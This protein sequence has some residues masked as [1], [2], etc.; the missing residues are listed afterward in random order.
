MCPPARKEQTPPQPTDQST[1]VHATTV[2]VDDRAVLIRGASGAGKSALALQL[3]AHGAGLV[4]DDRTR[5]WRAGEAVVADAPKAIRGQ[6]EA[7]GVGI[8][9]APAF[10]PCAVSLV[11]DLDEDEAD[12][13]PPTRTTQ[14][15][16]V[17]LPLL[18]KCPGAHFPAA[19]ALYL[20]GGRLE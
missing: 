14:V 7:R 19:L 4:A 18:R 11:V 3:M 6:I 5:L 15:L 20:K 12:R 1:T 13:L 8:L 9:S 10:G 2:A 16:G 17:A